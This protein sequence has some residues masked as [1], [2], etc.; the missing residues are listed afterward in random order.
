M[1]TADGARF[2]GFRVFPTHRLLP[3]QNLVRLRRRLQTMQAGFANGEIELASIRQR[4][5]SWLGHAMHA[6]TA[7]L[8]ANVFDSTIFCRTTAEQ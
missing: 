8:R 2:L 3:R 7:R 4:L 5:V 1:R 6:N